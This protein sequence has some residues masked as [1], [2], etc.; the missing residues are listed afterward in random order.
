MNPSDIT[1]Q[2]S[3]AQTIRREL[4]EKIT[5]DACPLR[6]ASRW[7]FLKKKLTRVVPNLKQITSVPLITNR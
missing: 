2:E 6:S 3:R 1:A 7:L 4:K 5:H